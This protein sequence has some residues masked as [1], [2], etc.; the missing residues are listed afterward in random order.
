MSLGRG[1]L[2]PNLAWHRSWDL[3][4]HAI[5]FWV[6]LPKYHFFACGGHITAI[7]VPFLESIFEFTVFCFPQIWVYRFP[8]ITDHMII[9]GLSLPYN[10]SLPIWVYQEF[11]V[12]WFEFTTRFEFMIWVYHKI[13]SLWFE[14]TKIWVY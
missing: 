9:F 3:L 14:F 12:Y 4:N 10:S 1:K 11:S 6:Y 8:F 2:K 5:F 7:L 13:Y